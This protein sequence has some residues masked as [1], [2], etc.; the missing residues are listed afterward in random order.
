MGLVLLGF[1]L[2]ATVVST[3][4]GLD[5]CIRFSCWLSGPWVGHWMEM[6]VELKTTVMAKHED[7]KTKMVVNMEVR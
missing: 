2:R 5:G 7:M 4:R 6:K 3:L 1:A